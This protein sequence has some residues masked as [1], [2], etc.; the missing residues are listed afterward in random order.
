MPRLISMLCM[1][2][3]ITGIAVPSSS[4]AQQLNLALTVVTAPSERMSNQQVDRIIDLMNQ[5]VDL[6]D[7]CDRL[8]IHRRGSVLQSKA[9]PSLV[10]TED[11][12]G[13]AGQYRQANVA[14]VTAINYCGRPA[15]ST[16]VG[17]AGRGTNIVVE[18]Y[19]NDVRTALLW[20]HEIGHS[21]GLAWDVDGTS[22][23]ANTT[24]LM[25]RSLARSRWQLDP[26]ECAR[27]ISRGLTFAPSEAVQP[28]QATGDIRDL[29]IDPTDL[30]PLE[31]LL[32]E[33][34]VHRAP[35]ERLRQLAEE[36][37]AFLT[38]LRSIL[39]DEMKTENVG[40]HCDHARSV[41][42]CK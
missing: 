23:S 16:V 11:D 22:H 25:Y 28:A 39:I 34:W 35:W 31:A 13:T 2:A 29:L 8:H 33:V 15:P 9:I 41:W 7:G 32:S 36:T 38:R 5:I 18:N 40:K 14:V 17:C 6:N 19:G 30:D 3:T 10:N 24:R 37:P 1:V 42:R 20:L 27:M 12:F 21:Q 4:S 26:R